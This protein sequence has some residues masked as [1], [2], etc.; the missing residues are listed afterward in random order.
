MEMVFQLRIQDFP[1]EAPTSGAGAFRRK[2][3]KMKELGLG[4]GGGGHLCDTL[5]MGVK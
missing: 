5:K 1:L 2:H 4:G 3:A